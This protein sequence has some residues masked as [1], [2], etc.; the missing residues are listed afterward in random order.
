MSTSE[1]KNR[2]RSHS[3]RASASPGNVVLARPSTYEGCGLL[4]QSNV[5][6]LVAG[7]AFF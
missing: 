5:K 4:L 1:T 7:V 2:D 6:T 3:Y